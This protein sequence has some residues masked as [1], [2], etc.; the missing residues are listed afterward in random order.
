ML[1]FLG[2]SVLLTL[3]PKAAVFV[4]VVPQFVEPGAGAATRVALLLLVYGALCLGFWVGF[5]L[6]LHHAR[7]LVRRP[8]VRAWME[9]LTGGAL[10]G[11]GARLAIVR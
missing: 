8:R 9:R 6:I 10:I 7:E 5:V 4:A 1:T 11:L 2:L 3:N